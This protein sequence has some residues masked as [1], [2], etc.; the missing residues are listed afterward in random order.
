MWH[1]RAFKQTIWALAF[2]FCLLGARLWWIN[3]WCGADYVALAQNQRLASLPEYEYQRGDFLDRYGE[4]FTNRA[5]RVLLVF[6]GLLRAADSSVTAAEHA[7]Y[8]T[9]LLAELGLSPAPAAQSLALRLAGNTPFVLARGLTEQQQ[10]ALEQ[11][12]NGHDGL[13]TA[14][15]HPRYAANSPAA[16]LIGYVGQSTAEEEA[17]LTAAGAADPEYIGKSGLEQQFDEAL[18]GRASARLA[19]AIDEQG[20]QASDIL[21]ELQPTGEDSS[22]NV[23]LTLDYSYQQICEA[24]MQGKNGAAVLLDV[25]NGDV[26]ALVSSPGFNQS[27]G[28]PPNDGD[29]YLNKAFGYYPPASVFKLVLTLAALEEGVS[30]DDET[31]RCTGAVT[32]PNG[33]SVKCWQT[34]GHGAEDLTTALG[35]SC[36]PYFIT[37]G[38]KLGGALIREYAWRLGMTEQV[39]RGFQLPS[40]NMLDFNDSVPADVANVSIGE[41]G[42]RAT[43]LM[44]ARLLAAIANDGLLPEPRLVI[45]LETAGGKVVE[46]FESAEPRQVVSKESARTLAKMLAAAVNDGTGK[47]VRS[48]LIGIGG[49]TGTSQNFGVWFAGFFPTDEP[50]WAMAVYIADGESGGQDA[51]SVCREV[52]EKLALLENIANQSR[53]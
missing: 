15:Y 29:S 43:P 28:Q 47:P 20:R 14:L 33:H 31:F 25:K 41:K 6:P 23:R 13:F 24:A 52:A 9:E 35:N 46:S 44:L 1:S 45:S 51:G 26:L 2:C 10:T 38:Q 36:N 5:E 50:R 11:K 48:D 8:L 4:S 49:K 16:H 3:G 21:R 22:L 30:I 34:D 18:R 37:L 39:L 40:V 12:I 19:A 32:L 17:A 27:V 53:V 7:T 42:I